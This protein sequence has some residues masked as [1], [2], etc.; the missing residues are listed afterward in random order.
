M[1]Y[2]RNYLKRGDE[3]TRENDAIGFDVV[4]ELVFPDRA[5]LLAWVAKLSEPG[6]GARVVEDEERFLDRSRYWAYV[7]EERVTPG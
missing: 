4:T 1:V 3:F 5:A 6:T 7:I 2:K